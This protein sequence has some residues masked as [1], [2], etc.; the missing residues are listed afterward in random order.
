MSKALK[1]VIAD[2]HPIIRDGF[3]MILATEDDMEVVGVAK[4]GSE[5]VSLVVEHKPDVVLLDLHMPGKTGMEALKEIKHTYPFTKILIISSFIDDD[6]VIECLSNGASG[7]LLK[8]WPTEKIITSMK[9]SVKNQLVIPESYTNKL[10]GVWKKDKQVA[11]NIAKD[12]L[13]AVEQMNLPLNRRE[14]EIFLK[15]MEGKKT[16]ILQVNYS[17]PLEL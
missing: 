8:D 3:H 12:R 1:V 14:K 11:T 17:F 16:M 2:D 6:T 4:D 9:D 7:I 10:I 13:T 15:V 5:A